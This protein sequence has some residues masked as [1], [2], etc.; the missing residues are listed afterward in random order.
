MTSSTKDAGK[1]WLQPASK[2]N[3]WEGECVRV[4]LGGEVGRLWLGCKE[5]K[6]WIIERTKVKLDHYLSSFTKLGAPNGWRYAHP[7]AGGKQR[8]HTSTMGTESTCQ[9]WAQ[10]EHTSSMGTERAHINYGHR[11]GLVNKTPLTQEIRTAIN[12]GDLV[13]CAVKKWLIQWTCGQQSW[14]QASSFQNA[15]RTKKKKKNLNT[16][17]PKKLKWNVLCTSQKFLQK[18]ETLLNVLKI[19]NIPTHQRNAD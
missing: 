13:K 17:E 4:G 10:R 19:L 3:C 6:K 2:G 7:D 18:S 8:E 9:P 1:P 16:K 12:R 11:P 14:K 15:K 5:N